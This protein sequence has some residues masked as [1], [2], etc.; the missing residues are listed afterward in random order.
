MLPPAKRIVNRLFV[1]DTVMLRDLQT[2]ALEA[3]WGRQ[4]G[5]WR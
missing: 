3:D 1:A 2:V 5:R 4:R